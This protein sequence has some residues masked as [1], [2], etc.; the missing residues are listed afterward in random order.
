MKSCN[1]GWQKKTDGL[2][3]VWD[4]ATAFYMEL[5]MVD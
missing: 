2:A 1:S 4:N 5:L 3:M